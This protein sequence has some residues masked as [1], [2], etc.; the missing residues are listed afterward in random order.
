MFLVDKKTSVISTME[1]IN[2]NAKGI[3]FLVD[4]NYVVKASI[5]DGDIR[6]H[7]L[8]GND[9]QG[10]VS[11]CA[12][13]NFI[14]LKEQQ[15]QN[16]NKVMNEKNIS[17]LPILDEEG[18]LISLVFSKGEKLLNTSNLNVPVVIM[19]GGKGTRLRPYSNI[20]PKPLIPIGDYTITERII[21]KFMEFNCN[22]FYMIVNHKRKLIKA[23]FTDLG[24][25]TSTANADFPNKKSKIIAK[26]ANL[27]KNYSIEFVNEDTDLGTGGGL[28]L[29]KGIV[30]E[31][32]FMTNC[33]II[34]NNRY[35]KILSY[36]KQKKNLITLV[37]AAKN[38]VVPY[39]TLSL[40]K[41]GEILAFNEKPELPFLVN[42]GLYLI[43]PKF[44]DYIKECEFIHI[45]DLIKRC[46]ASGEK[47]GV[48]PTSESSW[49]DM[50]QP[51]ELEKM[52]K[53]Y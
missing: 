17:C 2:K 27:A 35:D 37:C 16:Y 19:A 22:N 34:V 31:T 29:L 6:R 48:F 14:F 5:T 12:N 26:S 18:K 13:Y 39:G 42:T 25:A 33:D 20:L 15:T 49:S 52:L 46:M 1:I 40:N 28:Y 11:L 51:E 9:L 24:M 36:H 43:E 47:I 50:G 32:F 8:N 7:I 44:L 4:E 53:L 23:Y 10:E 30:K 38:F 21:E 45:T 41:N 3:T